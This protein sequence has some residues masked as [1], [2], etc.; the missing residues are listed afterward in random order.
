LP[1]PANFMFVIVVLRYSHSG[2]RALLGPVIINQTNVTGLRDLRARRSVAFIERDEGRMARVASEWPPCTIDL[3]CRTCT[4]RPIETKTL[5]DL[6][7]FALP[8]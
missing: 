3:P 4:T 7:R 8:T 6:I 5:A 2:L 1:F